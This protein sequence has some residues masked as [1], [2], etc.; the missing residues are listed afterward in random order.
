MP[1]K[2]VVTPFPAN[3]RN[4]RF[5]IT[6]HAKPQHKS[7][8]AKPTGTFGP[9]KCSAKM[10]EI[11]VLPVHRVLWDTPEIYKLPLSVRKNIGFNI[12]P[13]VG[14]RSPNIE[15]SAPDGAG[16][17][18]SNAN[19]PVSAFL[20]PAGT[21]GGAHCAV[22]HGYKWRGLIVIKFEVVLEGVVE[23]IFVS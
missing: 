6:A 17:D 5:E 3:V 9:T 19:I 10:A 2:T 11:T 22:S 18:D 21:I 12:Q 13:K 15:R 16:V 14:R 4:P 20:H 8:G 1:I 23:F 7:A